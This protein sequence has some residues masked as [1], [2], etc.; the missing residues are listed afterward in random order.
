MQAERRGVQTGGGVAEVRLL[1]PQQGGAIFALLALAVVA[2]LVA[3]DQQ[4]DEEDAEDG[5]RVEE[6]EIE[7]GLVGARH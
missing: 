3:N 4:G 7:E 5:E 2:T 1:N 6:E